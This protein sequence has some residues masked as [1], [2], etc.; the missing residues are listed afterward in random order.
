[1]LIWRRLSPEFSLSRC[2][3]SHY[4]RA[5]ETCG[6]RGGKAHYSVLQT[7]LSLSSAKFFRKEASLKSKETFSLHK[8]FRH[9][10]LR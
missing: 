5:N 6:F 3:L 4:K 8:G 10:T 7:L 1:M 2:N 9:A